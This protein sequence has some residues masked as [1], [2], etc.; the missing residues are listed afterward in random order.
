MLV[1]LTNLGEESS[2]LCHLIGKTLE[3]VDVF[4]SLF[5]QSPIFI[6]H[7]L[8]ARHSAGCQGKNWVLKLDIP[9]FTISFSHIL[10]VRIRI[11]Y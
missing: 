9:G 1:D 3:L 8:Y 7:L 10:A 4:A 2:S 11:N 6:K 5:V